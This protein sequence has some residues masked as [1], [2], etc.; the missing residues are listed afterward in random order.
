MFHCFPKKCRY[1]FMCRHLACSRLRW[2]WYTVNCVVIILRRTAF[3]IGTLYFTFL[4]LVSITLAPPFCWH[5]MKQWIVF[6]G[7]NKA[8]SFQTFFCEQARIGSTK[9]SII[10][11]KNSIC[12]KWTISRKHKNLMSFFGFNIWAIQIRL[13]KFTIVRN[14]SMF[15]LTSSIYLTQFCIVSFINF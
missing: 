6:V 1:K 3:G 15:E 10:E 13:T 12:Q 9:K 7:N 11:D 2:W 14:V 8:F 5:F 4:L